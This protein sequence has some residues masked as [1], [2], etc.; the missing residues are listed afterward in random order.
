MITRLR[1][2]GNAQLVTLGPE[3]TDQL[4]RHELKSLETQQSTKTQLNLLNER[5]EEAFNTRIYEEDIT[6]GN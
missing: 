1:G 3:R 4:E 2:A 5:V 6:N